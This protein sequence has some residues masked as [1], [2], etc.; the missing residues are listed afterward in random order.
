LSR[1]IATN[2]F[3]FDEE[4]PISLFIKKLQRENAN[5]GAR[6]GQTRLGASDLAAFDSPTLIAVTLHHRQLRDN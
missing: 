2:R 5:L 6:N 3:G 1:L 4:A